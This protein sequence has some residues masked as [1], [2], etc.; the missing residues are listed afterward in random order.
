MLTIFLVQHILSSV[1]RVNM[2]PGS[3]SCLF[4]INEVRSKW[5]LMLYL[6]FFLCDIM[7]VMVLKL[8]VKNTG[9]ESMQWGKPPDVDHLI[10]VA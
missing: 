5:H 3:K 1:N 9:I 7:F 8:Q 2:S 6:S 10:L 4:Q